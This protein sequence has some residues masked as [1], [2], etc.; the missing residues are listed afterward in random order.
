[1]R[2]ASVKRTTKETDVE[3][4]VDLDGTGQS[5][6]STGIGFFDH[7]LDLLAR[8][9]RI[10]MTVAAKGEGDSVIKFRDRL[11]RRP[12]CLVSLRKRPSADAT[13]IPL[14]LEQ[15]AAG[16]VGEILQSAAGSDAKRLQV[17]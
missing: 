16:N 12:T 3:V 2:K 6:I 4:A 15:G 8:H 10:D 14:A 11:V 7:M 13:S 1:M 9:S 5:T 17:P